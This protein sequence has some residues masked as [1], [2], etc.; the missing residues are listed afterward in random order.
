MSR[1]TPRLVATLECG[2]TLGEG[3][4][5]DDRNDQAL[6][7]DIEGRALYRSGSPF[8]D[9][10]SL[11]SPERIGSFG[12][13]AERTDE[14]I[15]AFESGFGRYLPGADSIDWIDRPPLPPGARFNDGRV[16]RN[17]IFWAGA[18]IENPDLAGNATGALYRLTEGRSADPVI[19]DVMIPNSL[20]WSP[21]GRVMYFAD[22]LE[23]VIW[24]FDV[25]SGLPTNQRVFAAT[26]GDGHPDG[27]TVDAAG[28]LWNA[29]WGAGRVV[30]YRPDGRVDLSVDVPAPHTSCVAFA[31]PQRNLLLVTTA[32]VALDDDALAAAPESGN[33][34]I[35][36]TDC[37][38]LPES[39]CRLPV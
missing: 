37:E 1:S 31:G 8:D 17:G 25:D 26:T 19:D 24:A 4:L 23:R 34:F 15:V 39:R 29:E 7:T 22:T 27:S 21:D 6:W 5:W 9:F 28:C 35:F 36:E 33:L 16:D 38:G 10:E 30:R 11:P 32:R 14:L 18:M 3:V 13:L 20:C 12:L 2:N